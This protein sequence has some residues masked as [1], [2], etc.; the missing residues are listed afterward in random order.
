MKRI[1]LIL[2]ILLNT[3]VVH[4]LQVVDVKEIRINEIKNSEFSYELLIEYM[5]L[6]DLTFSDVPLRQFI[7]ESGRFKSKLFMEH[8][9]I[10]GMKLAKK[11]ET[12][13]IGT[14]LGHAKYNHWT[15]SV[16]DYILWLEFYLDKGYDVTNYYSFLK[17][18]G[19]AGI[20]DYEKRLKNIDL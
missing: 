8:N 6:K 19:Y 13:A 1:V 20:K 3:L 17:K 12:T 2:I 7:N 4:E 10:A 9:N 18:V 11:R 15:D 5:E 14:A 16:D